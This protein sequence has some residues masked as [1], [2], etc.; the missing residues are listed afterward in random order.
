MLLKLSA[1]MTLAEQKPLLP[2]S[3]VKYSLPMVRAGAT[4]CG[5]HRV[6]RP[7]RTVDPGAVPAIPALPPAGAAPSAD[8]APSFEGCAVNA[9]V[10]FDRGISAVARAIRSAVQ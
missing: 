5:L 3:R 9:E 7:P 1:L 8:C 4:P 2:S 6:A 10:P